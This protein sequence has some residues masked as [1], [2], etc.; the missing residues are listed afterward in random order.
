MFDDDGIPQE[1]DD[2]EQYDE[3]YLR[4]RGTHGHPATEYPER[5]GED[6]GD[7]FSE[8]D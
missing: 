7:C 5:E 6:Y 3:E 4:A 2:A 1:P 8:S